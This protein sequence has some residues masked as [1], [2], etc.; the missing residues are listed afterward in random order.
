MSSYEILSN[1]SSAMRQME[2]VEA[3]ENI[4]GREVASLHILWLRMILMISITF[5]V[6]WLLLTLMMMAI[7]S[8]LRNLHICYFEASFFSGLYLLYCPELYARGKTMCYLKKSF[9]FFALFLPFWTRNPGN[10][11]K[12]PWA[13]SNP[14]NPLL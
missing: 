14:L 11:T 4:I 7:Y 9:R 12:R 10:W 3:K 13:Y 1:L 2:K 5:V 8:K 6:I